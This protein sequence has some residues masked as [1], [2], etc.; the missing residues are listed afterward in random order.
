MYTNNMACCHIW[1]LI[2]KLE[3]AAINMKRIWQAVDNHP[4]LSS[5]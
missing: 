3:E 2:D 5:G 4:I 1:A